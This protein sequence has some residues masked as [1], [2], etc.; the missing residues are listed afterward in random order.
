MLLHSLGNLVLLSRSKNS[1][2]QNKDFDFKKKH[3]DKDGN[4]VGFFNGSYSE[5]EISN[6]NEWNASV[7]LE[8]GIKMLEFM[9]SRWGIDFNEWEVKPIDILGLG[10][11]DKK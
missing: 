10:F 6:Y 5:I 11:L 8:R 3:E 7:I 9:E 4:R 2:L 1:E